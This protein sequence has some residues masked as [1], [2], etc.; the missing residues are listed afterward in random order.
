MRKTRYEFT[1]GDRYAITLPVTKDGVAFDL[2]GW[3]VSCTLGQDDTQ[4]AVTEAEVPGAEGRCTL[5]VQPG[6]SSATLTICNSTLLEQGYYDIELRAVLDSQV[7]TWPK[8]QITIVEPL[9]I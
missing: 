4:V 9:G 8:W 2:T 6:N 1:R 7:Y 3:T 5:T